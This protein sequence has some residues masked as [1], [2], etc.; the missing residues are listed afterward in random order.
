ME[1][2][3]EEPLDEVEEKGN[4]ED[5]SEGPST[6]R[7]KRGK[8][9]KKSSISSPKP[10]VEKKQNPNRGKNPRDVW[11]PSSKRKQLSDEPLF[12]SWSVHPKELVLV[13]PDS[14]ELQPFLPSYKTSDKFCIDDEEETIDL[15]QGKTMNYTAR[16]RSETGSI[17]FTG[18]SIHSVEWCPNASDVQDNYVAA[19]I[20]SEYDETHEFCKIM[21]GPNMIQIW[22]MGSMEAKKTRAGKFVLGVLHTGHHVRDMKWCPPLGGQSQVDCRLGILALSLGDASVCM[23]AVP[24]PE[25]I[26][27]IL[28]VALPMYV[29]MTPVKKCQFDMP[30]RSLQWSSIESP[31]YML[32]SG[33]DGCIYVWTFDPT[34]DQP[35]SSPILETAFVIENAH[36]KGTAGT[37]FSPDVSHQFMSVGLDQSIKLWDLRDPYR[38]LR[39]HM[40]IGG[41]PTAFH[42]KIPNAWH[43]FPAGILSGE[44]GATLCQWDWINLLNYGI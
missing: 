34:S 25:R 40:Y 5:D 8:A 36:K 35:E 4:D 38:P 18:G 1:E 16:K 26:A 14:E 17:A 9:E 22:N 31:Q 33:A 21:E 43:K 32:G 37:G 19:A 10:T 13:Q 44:D 20:Y 7:P 41:W 6:P 24:F 29:K 39:S 3:D 12:P 2:V 11:G 27:E 28:Q 30:M 23:Y 42:W 15:L